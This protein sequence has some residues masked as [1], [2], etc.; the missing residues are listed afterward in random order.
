MRRNL[1]SSEV[2]NLPLTRSS[3]KRKSAP[4][5]HC[6]TFIS[7]IN[8]F[9]ARLNHPLFIHRGMTNSR[10]WESKQFEFK[11]RTIA[12][13]VEDKTCSA[14]AQHFSHTNKINSVHF[15][16]LIPSIF[17]L[18]WSGSWGGLFGE[19]IIS[20]FCSIATACTSFTFPLSTQ[21]LVTIDN[22]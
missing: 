12:P 13:T 14:T 15:P 21:I 1:K 5:I 22:S 9:S 7:W 10:V 18:K 16:L 3:G 6:Q 19:C 2:Q 8:F 20:S 11:T 17:N 4:S